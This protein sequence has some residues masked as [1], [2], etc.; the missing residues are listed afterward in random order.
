MTGMIGAISG[1]LGQ[2]GHGQS[3][4]TQSSSGGSDI[5]EL[6]QQLLAALQQA[7]D[8]QGQGSNS[9]DK[10]NNSNPNSTGQN[11]SPNNVTVDMHS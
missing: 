7:G 10:N 8:S 11:G 4:D 2:Q 1:L 3:Q 6:I 5:K 9:C